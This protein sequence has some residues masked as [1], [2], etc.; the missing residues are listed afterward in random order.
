MERKSGENIKRCRCTKSKAGLITKTIIILVFLAL[1]TNCIKKDTDDSTNGTGNLTPVWVYS[2]VEYPRYLRMSK[3][4][5]YAILA[6]ESKVAL[7]D[8]SKQEEII[9]YQVT[10]DEIGFEGVSIS[11]SG[12]AIA[13]TFSNMKVF[14]ALD[15]TFLATIT[16][17]NGQRLRGYP[18]ILTPSGQDVF[19][20]G[21]LRFSLSGGLVWYNPVNL[22]D[23]YGNY[24][25][26][27]D[28]D[29]ANEMVCS[30]DG[31]ILVMESSIYGKL[32][33]FNGL[34][35]TLSW[36]C[37]ESFDG[38]AELAISGNGNVAVAKDLSRI[39]FFLTNPP[40]LLFTRDLSRTPVNSYRSVA[41]SYDGNIIAVGDMSRLLIFKNLSSNPTAIKETNEGEILNIDMSD[42]GTRIV[43]SSYFGGLQIY[44]QNGNLLY[45]HDSEYSGA[46]S[47]ANISRDGKTVTCIYEN[48]FHM[49]K[50]K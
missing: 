14:Y 42:D 18:V 37:S 39:F 25:P 6:G 8:L 43:I 16:E 47:E 30:R 49:Y 28:Y 45:A 13:T 21:F 35:G 4:G 12:Y 5:K 36:R 34:N 50:L 11:E 29:F 3:D 10:S 31:T 38:G 40:S 27:P 1:Q 26:N 46:V 2:G 44:D 9:S 20:F 24:Y 15:N 32:S 48:K 33:I 17:V 23:Q 7:L 22:Q 19:A 41:V